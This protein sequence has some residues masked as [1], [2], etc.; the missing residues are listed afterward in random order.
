MNQG[1]TADICIYSSLTELVYFCQGRFYLSSFGSKYK[2]TKGVFSIC[3]YFENDG[4]IYYSEIKTI[5][6]NEVIRNE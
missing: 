2:R 4:M 6:K 3:L 1:G 5:I